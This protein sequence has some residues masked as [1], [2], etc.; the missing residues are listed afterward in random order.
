MKDKT[1]TLLVS[2]A[3]SML[4]AEAME[5]AVNGVDFNLKGYSLEDRTTEF[6][7]EGTA[8]NKNRVMLW[9]YSKPGDY[10]RQPDKG[11]PLYAILGI[12]LSKD[13]AD[14]IEDSITLSF[15]NFFSPDLELVDAVVQPD[16]ANK[17]WIITLY[18]KDPIRRE[19]FDIVL[20][21]ASS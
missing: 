8:A 16:N 17:R 15:N 2:E 20:G 13:N 6:V 18:V 9:L 19:L 1:T 10:V 11:G 14:A 3:Q 4:F 12:P 5:A 21:A 7:L